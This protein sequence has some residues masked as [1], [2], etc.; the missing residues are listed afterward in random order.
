[1]NFFFV[2]K[3]IMFH[4]NFGEMEASGMREVREAVKILIFA[5]S[6]INYLAF[7]FRGW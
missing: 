5:E 6:N 4:F 2:L 3:K 1:M 7:M